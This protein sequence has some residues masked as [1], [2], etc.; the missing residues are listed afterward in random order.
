MNAIS[1]LLNF[2]AMYFGVV[3]VT[4]TDVASLPVTITNNNILAKH[5]CTKAV[6]SNPS[7]Q[8]SDWTVTTSAASAEITGT[9]SDTTNITLYLELK[10]N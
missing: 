7:A 4:A 10:T 1:S 6:L 3:E 9:I 5:V 8:M 2:I